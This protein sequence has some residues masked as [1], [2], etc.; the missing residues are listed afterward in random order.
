MKEQEQ[1]EKGESNNRIPSSANDSE[2]NFQ[3][4]LEEEI[5][6]RRLRRLFRF[7]SSLSSLRRRISSLRGSK[8]S[9]QGSAKSLERQLAEAAKDDDDDEE[10][11][12]C[13][14]YVVI[15][16]ESSINY[17]TAREHNIRSDAGNH[18]ISC[19]PSRPREYGRR[20]EE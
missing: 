20:G 10:D 15:G 9:L 14:R 16:P 17:I 4:E 1:E 13:V 5:R 8:K 3:D 19:S 7:T 11:Q 12:D 2:R 18:V 6:V